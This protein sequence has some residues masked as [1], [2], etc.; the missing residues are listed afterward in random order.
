MSFPTD[1]YNDTKA[2]GRTKRHHR[3]AWSQEGSRDGCMM[4]L[5][6]LCTE[7]AIPMPQSSSST[8]RRREQMPESRGDNCCASGVGFK[9]SGQELR[10][11]YWGAHTGNN[12]HVVVKNLNHAGDF[13]WQIRA[14]SSVLN[15][16][17]SKELLGSWMQAYMNECL[18]NAVSA[19]ENPSYPTKWAVGKTQWNY[20]KLY[21]WK[22][23][24]G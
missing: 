22:F 23:R 16:N 14:K 20:S 18:V 15:C 7:L 4:P 8:G 9:Q 6:T 5:L 17:W 21:L 19:L 11:N 12:A 10:L 3:M 24:T 1:F 2:E 13:S